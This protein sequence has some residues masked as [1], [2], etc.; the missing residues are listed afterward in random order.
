MKVEVYRRSRISTR[1]LLKGTG[2]IAIGTIVF[3][4][5]ALW[6]FDLRARDI[7]ISGR[8][9][10]SQMMADG[11]A[12]AIQD[13]VIARNFAQLESRLRQ[14][15]S[16]PQVLSI[17]VAD[18]DGVVL[19]EM[20]RDTL[21][22]EI[23]PTYSYKKTTAPS[24]EESVDSNN[25]STTRWLALKAGVPIGGLKLEITSKLIDDKLI[26]LRRDVGIALL[27]ACLILFASIGL[28][29]RRTHSLIR[30][31]EALMD[32]KS[33]AL[34]KIAFNDHLT[35]LP[36]RL[37]LLDRI[38]QAIVFSDRSGK[39]FVL[40][41]MDLNGFKLI[42]DNYGHDIGD[43]VLKEVA[44]RLKDSVRASDT[45][46]RIGG[47]EFVLLLVEGVDGD[48][49]E[50]VLDRVKKSI[51]QPIRLLSGNILQV[52]I[53]IGVTTYPIDHSSPSDMLKHADQAM[54]QA[55]RSKEDKF[56]IYKP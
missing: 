3:T 7:R 56:R 46:A 38:G 20:Q 50:I 31:E 4:L 16:D 5:I 37:L 51:H 29:L 40:C 36:N 14:A 17:M 27:G 9:S 25:L 12:I 30:V 53:S 21:T 18:F 33:E 42:N 19:S 24:A 2:Y 39:N 28:V 1:S 43:L 23:K 55:K 10:T 32:G 8:E 35:G 11:I 26:D 34:E 13:D 49:F 6:L 52:G 44:T 15:I 22:G 47:D 41:F 48:G 45:V 54:Y